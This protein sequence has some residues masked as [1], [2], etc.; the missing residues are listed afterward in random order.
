MRLSLKLVSHA[1]TEVGALAASGPHADG[2]AAA[3]AH[4]RVASTPSATARGSTDNSDRWR[5]EQSAW[6][7]PKRGPSLR[8]DHLATATARGSRQL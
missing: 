8:K 2:A 6:R 5:Q 3:C 1:N 7:I 4:M